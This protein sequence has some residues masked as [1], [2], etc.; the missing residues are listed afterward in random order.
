MDEIKEAADLGVLDGVTTNPSLLSKEIQ[1][2]GEDYKDILKNICQIVQGPVSAEVLALDSEGMIREA[3]ELAQ[4]DEHIVVKVPI[5][6]DGLKAVKKLASEGIKTNVTLT[7]SS[8][9]ALSS[10]LIAFILQGL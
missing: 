3:M 9:Q 6:K 4:L 7:F 8:C 5:I 1:R 10:P 2:S